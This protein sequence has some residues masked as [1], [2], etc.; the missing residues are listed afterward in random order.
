MGKHRACL[1]PKEKRLFQK[2]DRVLYGYKKGEAAWIKETIPGI[3]MSAM[4][5]VRSAVIFLKA[6]SV[7]LISLVLDATAF[8][9]MKNERNKLLDLCWMINTN[10]LKLI[11]ADS[12]NKKIP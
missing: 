12:G 2:V 10:P 11:G 9:R 5:A 8:L 3:Y 4:S 7:Q 6:G 1:S